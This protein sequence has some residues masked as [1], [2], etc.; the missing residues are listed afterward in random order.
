MELPLDESGLDQKWGHQLG[1]FG[2]CCFREARLPK[3]ST[4][5]QVGC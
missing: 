2:N 5:G 3:K 1:K 4:A